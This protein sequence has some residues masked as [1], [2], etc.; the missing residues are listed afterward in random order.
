MIRES[1]GDRERAAE[2]R[3]FPC[4]AS[5]AHNNHYV[6]PN[7]N[8][9]KK[10]ARITRRLHKAKSTFLL[11]GRPLGRGL[12]RGIGLLPAGSGEKG[13][14]RGADAEQNMRD[15]VSPCFHR[16]SFGEYLGR[17]CLFKPPYRVSDPRGYHFLRI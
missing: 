2:R 7:A 5:I 12:G 11:L 17:V 4:R 15:E 9:K 8:G 3:R 1:E 14:Q 10:D 13:D 6:N 16:V